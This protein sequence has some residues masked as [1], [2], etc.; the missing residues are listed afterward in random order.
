M[1]T[2]ET[3]LQQG[4]FLREGNS[5]HLDCIILKTIYQDSHSSSRFININS[6][7]V[8]ILQNEKAP[9]AVKSHT[10][11]KVNEGLADVSVKDVIF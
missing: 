4:S 2:W 6:Q 7:N 9:P 5:L 3:C 8:E 10:P 1:R 11:L